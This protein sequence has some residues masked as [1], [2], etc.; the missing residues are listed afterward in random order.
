MTDLKPSTEGGARDPS[1]G[2]EPRP[3]SGQQ[4]TPLRPAHAR[5]ARPTPTKLSPASTTATAPIKPAQNAAQAAAVPP[6]A[7]QS[8]GHSCPHCDAD[9]AAQ[10]TFCEACGGPLTPTATKASPPTAAKAAAIARPR[11]VNSKPA[12]AGK[13]SPA[14]PPGAAAIAETAQ[15]GAI[16]AAVPMKPG[17]ALTEP[18]ET[19]GAQST[20]LIKPRPA[21]TQPTDQTKPA[22]PRPAQALPVRPAQPRAVQTAPITPGRPGAAQPA[23]PTKTSPATDAKAPATPQR[24]KDIEP[25][26]A[27]SNAGPANSA[28]TAPTKPAQPSALLAPGP[29]KPSVAN[30]KA[31]TRPNTPIVPPVSP[32]KPAQTGA[33]HGAAASTRDSAVNQPGSPAKLAK[34][35]AAQAPVPTK[36]DAEGTAPPAFS[37]QPGPAGTKTAPADSAQPDLEDT[38][39]AEALIRAAMAQS[40]AITESNPATAAPPAST[41]PDPGTS[42]PAGA[43]SEPNPSTAHSANPNKPS[44]VKTEPAAKPSKNGRILAVALASVAGTLVAVLAIAALFV[45]Q[46]ERSLTDNLDREDLMP[47]DS[48]AS[49]P[50]K[51]QAA[52]EALN[53]VVMGYDS[54]DPSVERSS[55]LMILHLNAKRDQ[56]YFISFP[57]DT[58]VSIPGNRNDRINAAYRLGG[59]KL[60]VSTLEALTDT[61]MD[62]A[63]LVDVQGFA[64]LTDEVGGVTVYN[65]T[66]FKSHGFDYPKGNITVSGAR[67][68][69]FVG[70]RNSLPRGDFDRAANERNL[71]QAIIAKTLSKKTIRDPGKLFSVVSSASEHLTVDKGLSNSKIRSTIFSLRLSNKDVHLMKAPVSGKAIRRDQRVDIVDRDKLGELRTALRE[72]KVD[73]YLAKYPQG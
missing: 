58:W 46:V 47:T 34:A 28:A 23:A 39:A 64:R 7:I 15:S 69:Y 42:A 14:T 4:A 25:D 44:P 35:S 5:G 19:N 45:N 62:H 61:R 30:A 43:P 50:T 18:A 56:A 26:S 12:P 57:R 48:T 41:K 60:T 59:S 71:V 73:E 31:P 10:E 54:R 6:E 40:S 9:V 36:T 63:A 24:P 11:P 33:A 53:L 51:E 1:A 65:R 29:S 55:S 27:A 72:D 37:T 17:S 21:E 67:A 3:A 66:A 16:Q 20:A 22:Q 38:Q 8:G 68:L 13:A 52:G 2:T 32:T 49:H 70:E